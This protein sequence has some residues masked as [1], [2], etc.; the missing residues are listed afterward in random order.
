ML[1]LDIREGRAREELDELSTGAV[2]RET[3][4]LFGRDDDGALFAVDGHMLG[5]LFDGPER[6]KGV[7]AARQCRVLQRVGIPS[8]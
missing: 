8:G 1:E 7:S 5:S 6:D 3:V 2:A 4:V